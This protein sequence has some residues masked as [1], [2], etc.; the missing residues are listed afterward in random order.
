MAEL[1]HATDTTFDAEVLDSDR[2]VLVDFWADW[3]QPCKM[4]E[5]HLKAIATEMSDKLRVVKV[6]MDESPGV[7]G[8]FGVL[9][10]P[11]VVLF[12]N[13]E[14]KVRLVGARPKDAIVSEI[15]RFL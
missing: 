7:A 2:P 8:R 13:G 1:S 5:P 10:I 9:S 15:K 11:T 4:I 12:D 6:D 3:C 14:E